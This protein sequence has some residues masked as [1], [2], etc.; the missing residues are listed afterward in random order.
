MRSINSK[1]PTF[2][3]AVALLAPTLAISNDYGVSALAVD[4]RT[5]HTIYAGTGGG[6]VYRST[7]R[8]SSWNQTGLTNVSVASLVVDLL[9]PSTVYAV[10]NGTILKSAD[11]GQS[12]SGLNPPS[13]AASVTALAI[14][15]S[16]P[17]ILYAALHAYYVDEWEL[18]RSSGGVAKSTDGGMSWTSV[19]FPSGVLALVTD[20]LA[21]A[22]LVAGTEQIGGGWG[23]DPYG[24]VFTSTDGGATWNPLYLWW[25]SVWLAAAAAH[26]PSTTICV[27][28]SS[29]AHVNLSTGT[30][31][32]P[33]TGLA[34]L[35][36]DPHNRTT[37]YAGGG[38][39]VAKTTDGGF[40]WNLTNP[41]KDCLEYASCI[42]TALAI[43]AAGPNTL[44][45]GTYDGRVH[46]S[47][48]GGV[49]WAVVGLTPAVQ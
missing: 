24:D 45:A 42:V 34:S 13:D 41:E 18:L 35:A 19:S 38:N 46:K 3:A 48:D 17:A 31:G 25:G 5:P 26:G 16:N 33:L 49:T 32:Y 2:V 7:D 11:S 36:I 27:V 29:G 23:P 43:D 6:G 15:P 21:P 1:F 14:D 22:Q 47:T 10:A 37:V 44:Y 20:P 12:W 28:T 8:G 39:W 30:V 9:T 40:R 4:P